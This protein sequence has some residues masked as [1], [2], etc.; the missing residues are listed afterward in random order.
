M[1]TPGGSIRRGRSSILTDSPAAEAPPSQPNGALEKSEVAEEQAVVEHAEHVAHV[2]KEAADASEKE[3]VQVNGDVAPNEPAKT[4]GIDAAEP[5]LAPES[6]EDKDPERPMTPEKKTNSISRSPGTAGSR[7]SSD[8]PKT[9]RSVNRKALV[10][11]VH[12]V[13]K[14]PNKAED[15][16]AVTNTNGIDADADVDADGEAEVDAEYEVDGDVMM[17]K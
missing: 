1:V 17:Q 11:K 10:E 6:S 4:N 7:R 13:I 12:V 2:P 9:P 15:Q 3:P 8:N 14:S 16:N 5:G